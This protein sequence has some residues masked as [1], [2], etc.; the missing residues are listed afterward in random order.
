MTLRESNVL[1]E[2]DALLPSGYGTD[3]GTFSASGAG[4]GFVMERERETFEMG[5]SAGTVDKLRSE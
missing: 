3:N 4:E 2:A 5:R 1:K